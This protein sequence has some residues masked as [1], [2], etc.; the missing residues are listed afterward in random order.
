MNRIEQ[1]GI[2]QYPEKGKK[3]PMIDKNKYFSVLGELLNGHYAIIKSTHLIPQ[4]GQQYIDGFL[5]AG[6]ALNAVEYDELRD[7]IEKIHFETFG[8]TVEERRKSLKLTTGSIEDCLDVPTYV[9]QGIKL[10]F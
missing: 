6:R 2:N 4:E 3:H 7:F 1:F 9:R 10:E 5:A 8:M